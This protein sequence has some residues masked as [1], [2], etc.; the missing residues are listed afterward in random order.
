MKPKCPLC[1][2]PT[3]SLHPNLRDQLFGAVGVWHLQRC[4]DQACGLGSLQP[5]PT[6]A[7]ILAAYDSYH[8]HSPERGPT[9]NSAPDSRASKSLLGILWA[10]ARERYQAR[11]FGYTP[12]PLKPVSHA[13]STVLSWIIPMLPGHRADFETAVFYLDAPAALRANNAGTTLTAPRL[14]EVG[15]GS[16]KL[17]ARMRDFGWEV[18]GTDFDENAVKAASALTLDVR[19]GPLQAQNFAPESFDAVVLKHVLEHVPDPVNELRLCRSLLKPGGKLIVLTPNLAGRGHA[20]WQAHWRGLE[21]PRHLHI[22]TPPALRTV[23]EQSG[24]HLAELR[25][26]GRTR[27]AYRESLDAERLSAGKGN[28]PTWISLVL[29]ELDEWLEAM[30]RITDPLCGNELL[31]IAAAPT[32][33]NQKAP[34]MQNQDQQTP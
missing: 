9:Q 22:F 31:A 28:M 34:A 26:T 14:L 4:S 29:A 11:R 1:G 24:L 6:S 8:T 33:S 19:L 15:C 23:I 16:G 13:L 10:G 20:R 30:R 21:P 25:T 2:S 5:P 18:T 3:D 17:L 32:T 7:E 27:N 12:K